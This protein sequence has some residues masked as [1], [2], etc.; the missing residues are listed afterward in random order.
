MLTLSHTHIPYHKSLLIAAVLGC[1]TITAAFAQE[2]NN[3]VGGSP[4]STEGMSIMQK[5]A[6]LYRAQGLQMQ[7][8]GNIDGALSLYQKAIAVDPF[9]AVVYNDVGIIL[10]SKQFIDD[11]ESAYLKAINLD[12]N[13]LSAY[14][15]LALLYETRRDL[16]KAGMYWKKRISL[17]SADDPWT[18]K[19]E[20]RLRDIEYALG[21]PSWME[22]R[23]A[24]DLMNDVASRKEMLRESNQELAKDYFEKAKKSFAKND[25]PTALKQAQNALQLDPA[26]TE[27]E[28][29]IDKVQLR[30]LS[31]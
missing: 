28:E 20:R 2:Q 11:A 10:E 22:Q 26:N 8:M 14:S 13:F 29:F 9:Y 31:R 17:G 4:A 16:Q 15:N 12:P 27:F 19:A 30:A 21:G 7:R 23:E 18:I 5:Q 3:P 6:R 25:Y 1:M 24:V